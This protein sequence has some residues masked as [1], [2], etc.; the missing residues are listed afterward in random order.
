MPWAGQRNSTDGGFRYENNQVVS[1]LWTATP[2]GY[3]AIYLDIAPSNDG[4]GNQVAFHI[5]MN[6]T[7][8]AMVRCVR[9]EKE[10]R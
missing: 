10:T 9:Y 6:R 5:P 7:V 3:S 2:S 4:S 8:A 1:P